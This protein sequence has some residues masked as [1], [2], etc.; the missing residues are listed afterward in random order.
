MGLRQMGGEMTNSIELLRP[1]LK[2]DE[3]GFEK[4]ELHA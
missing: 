1:W 3:S 4:T 2:T